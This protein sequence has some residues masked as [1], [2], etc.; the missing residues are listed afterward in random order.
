MA[1]IKTKAYSLHEVRDCQTVGWKNVCAIEKARPKPAEIEDMSLTKATNH[2][3]P[4]AAGQIWKRQQFTGFE[5]AWAVSS[6]NSV[7]RREEGRKL[8]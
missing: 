5:K 7:S 2:P 3:M 8:H 1:T 6:I 4:S